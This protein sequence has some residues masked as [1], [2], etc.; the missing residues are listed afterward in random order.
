MGES[1][2]PTEMRKTGIWQ[3]PTSKRRVSRKRSTLAHLEKES[4]QFDIILNDIDKEGYPDTIEPVKAR[5]RPGGVFITDN[6][7]WSGR[8]ID[9]NTQQS[10]RAI[11]EFTRRLYADDDFIVSIIPVRDGIAIA[12]KK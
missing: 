1:S 5:L 11:Q 6:V 8:V 7:I 2:A 3:S 4:G 12:V 10:T 9:G